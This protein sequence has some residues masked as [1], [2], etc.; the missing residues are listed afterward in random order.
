MSSLATQSASHRLDYIESSSIYPFRF[1]GG[2]G[3]GVSDVRQSSDGIGTDKDGTDLDRVGDEADS[4]SSFEDDTLVHRHAQNHQ[5]SK[6][7][8]RV[9]RG[10]ASEDDEDDDEDVTMI[11]ADFKVGGEENEGID[12]E[13]ERAQCI[14]CLLPNRGNAAC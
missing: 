7:V 1:R 9:H 5:G 10:G 12:D 6:A 3:K 14:Q 4:S 8:E 13:T 11:F 2:A